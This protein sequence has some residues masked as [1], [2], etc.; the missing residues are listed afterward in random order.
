MTKNAG[1]VV[2]DKATELVSKLCTIDEL[3]ISK[4]LETTA[5]LDK[6]NSADKLLLVRQL[7]CVI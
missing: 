6:N 2:F 3:T 5:S 1:S 4:L 7:V